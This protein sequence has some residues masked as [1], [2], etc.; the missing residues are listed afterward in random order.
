MGR[1]QRDESV[2]AF[3]TGRRDRSR[4]RSINALAFSKLTK[5]HLAAPRETPP[6]G[7]VSR[8][9]PPDGHL[10]DASSCD[11]EAARCPQGHEMNFRTAK[12]G[13]CSACG[14]SVACGELVMDCRLCH[15]YL[16]PSCCPQNQVTQASR[17][18]MR[19][20]DD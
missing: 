5:S 4:A 9:V 2:D 12:G 8:H 16:C 11:S 7:K 10:D 6:R 3:G 14:V 19:H 1:S 20:Q 13:T 15:W 17:D 18:T